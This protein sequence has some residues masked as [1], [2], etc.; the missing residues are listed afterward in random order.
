MTNNRYI[1]ALVNKWRRL[2]PVMAMAMLVSLIIPGK[3]VAVEL[4]ILLYHRFGPRVTDSMTVTTEAFEAQLN[5]L[6]QKGY[7]VIPLQQWVDH[8]VAHVP[9][10][11]PRSV[12][13]TVDDGH[14]SVYTEM[15]PIVMRH[16]IPVTLFIYPSAISN[17]P[18]ALTWEQLRELRATGL[19]DIQSHTYWH[20]NFMREKR[21]L[22]PADYDRLVEM[23]L[24]KSKRVLE[25][26]LGT[27][28]DL[29]A[30]P[31]GLY[32]RDL[33]ERARKAGYIAAVTMERRS[34]RDDDDPMAIPRYLITGAVSGR[35]FS[36]IFP[37]P[38]TG[39][40]K[41]DSSGSV[42]TRKQ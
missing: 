32:D 6:E 40:R 34:A 41:N 3:C 11:P 25:M 31:Y 36:T 8:L 33:E 7:H 18:Y 14:R 2:G 9:P 19:F 22:S 4:P 20:P 27:K 26:R 12:V 10:P 16:R 35:A 24:T 15:L 21:Q 13:I 23:Q 30:W 1:P 28:V 5:E 17:A 42:K 29:L 37:A 38:K 39:E